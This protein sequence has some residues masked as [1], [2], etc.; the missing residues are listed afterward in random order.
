MIYCLTPSTHRTI[1]G[2]KKLEVLKNLPRIIDADPFGETWEISTL[3]SGP[4][5]YEGK[6][7]EIDSAIEELPYMVKLI[8]T[9]K[10]LSVQVHPDDEYARLHENSSGKAECYIIIEALEN[11]IL[12]LGL[13]PGIFFRRNS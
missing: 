5:L 6:T 11:A 3:P 4:S 12:Y 13:K 10:A 7:L 2:G 9:G 1:W 8:D